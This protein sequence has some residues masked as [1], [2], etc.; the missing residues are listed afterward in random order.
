MPHI[1][2]TRSYINFTMS[3]AKILANLNT[4]IVSRIDEIGDVILTFTICGIIQ[5]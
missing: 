4:I 5:K 3:N 1:K 2:N